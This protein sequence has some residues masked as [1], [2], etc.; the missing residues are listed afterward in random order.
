MS[1]LGKQL[2]YKPDKILQSTAKNNNEYSCISAA[3]YALL[4]FKETA[5]TSE[6]VAGLAL[7]TVRVI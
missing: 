3:P 2:T 7:G 4:V 1:V 5:V 6:Q